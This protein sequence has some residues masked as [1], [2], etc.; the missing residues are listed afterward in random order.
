MTYQPSFKMIDTQMTY[1]S[2]FKMIDTQMTYQPSF[3]MID[4]QMTYQPSVSDNI[5][6][7]DIDRT[8][9]QRYDAIVCNGSCGRWKNNTCQHETKVSHDVTIA[10][11]YKK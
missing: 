2:S 11:G 4:T 10:D 1:Q 7:C 5:S 9:E 3:K 8:A 6:N